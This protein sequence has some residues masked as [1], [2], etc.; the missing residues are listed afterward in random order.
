MLHLCPPRTLVALLSAVAAAASA[1]AA[2]DAATVFPA[3][4]VGYALA[5]SAEDLADRFA[6]TQVGRLAEDGTMKPF[7]DQVRDRLNRK[8][9]ALEQRLGVTLDD[10]R[11]AASGAA[12]VGIVKGA[13]K[14]QSGRV[15]A[16]VEAAGRDAEAKALLAKLD[17]RLV[18][19]GATKRAAGEITVYVLPPDEEADLPERTAAVFHVEGYL[20]AAEDE[21]IAADL[22]ARLRGSKVGK[23]LAEVAAYRE[24]Q[25]RARR[26]ARGADATLVWHLSPFEFEAA[27]RPAPAPGKAPDKKD[28]LAILASQGFDAV[29]G[30]GGVVT[31]AATPERDFVHHTF[32][33]APPKDGASGKPA[34]E[35]YRLGMRMLEL[36]NAADRLSKDNPPIELWAPRQVAT[37]KTVHVDVQNVFDH[38]PSTFDAFAGYEGAFKNIL[39]G[40]EKDPYGPKIDVRRDVIPHLGER[41][42]VMTDYTLPINPECERY[43]IVVDVKDEDALRESVDRWLAS[44][45]AERK[46]LD[47]V[48]YWEMVPEG[49]GALED[50]L[51]PLAP[52]DEPAAPRGE[53]E[54]RVLRRA[55]VCLHKGRL[56]IGSDA[57]FLRQA[58]FGSSPGESLSGSPDMRATIGALAEIAPEDRC[59]WTFTR[60]DE[61][62]RPSYELVREGKMPKAQTFFGRLLNRMMTSDDEREVGAEREQEIDGRL[63]P[64]FELARRYFGPS[65]RSVRSEDDGW[66]VSGV[67][68][69]KAPDT[70]RPAASVAQNAR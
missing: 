59:V 24:P 23:T 42:V 65:A 34:A 35:K 29:K 68:L 18:E 2:L 11:A 7:V 51:D 54:E 26:A 39:T 6:R 33:Y 14:G 16:V 8:F 37:Y 45:G 46:E 61:A 52:I 66:L 53:R 64:S 41:A 31:I 21:K 55:A 28:T 32:I 44:D 43:L 48:P 19:R 10:F 15:V 30:I 3:E 56:A 22:L 5:P 12:A 67:V 27:N 63:L 60:N 62:I 25:E 40:L 9:G 58:L 57:D 1:R 47:G 17:E 70:D 69:S 36:P 50:E 20:G 13:E 49:E 38:L 4:T